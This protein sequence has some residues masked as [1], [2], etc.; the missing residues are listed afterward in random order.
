MGQDA[1]PRHSVTTAQNNVSVLQLH[2]KYYVYSP[3]KT[4]PDLKNEQKCAREKGFFAWPKE[5]TDS[6][7]GPFELQSSR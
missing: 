1:L 4:E 3:I 6:H 7:A 5:R 2:D